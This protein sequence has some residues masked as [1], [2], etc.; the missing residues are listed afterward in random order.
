MCWSLGP[1]GTYVAELWGLTLYIGNPV[2]FLS[3]TSPE[4]AATLNSLHGP[5]SLT[6]AQLFLCEDGVALFANLVP[7]PEAYRN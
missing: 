2:S 6:H 1:K 7:A 3:L 5:E 4:P